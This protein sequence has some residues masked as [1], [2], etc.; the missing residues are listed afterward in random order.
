MIDGNHLEFYSRY[1]DLFFPET[2]IGEDGQFRYKIFVNGYVKS[3]QN[4]SIKF[5]YLKI[6]RK[7][8]IFVAHKEIKP[9]KPCFSKVS[10]AFTIIPIQ[11]LRVA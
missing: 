8:I 6:I 4:D 2:F 3:G 11:W 10:V 5:F 9:Q 7:C 1:Q